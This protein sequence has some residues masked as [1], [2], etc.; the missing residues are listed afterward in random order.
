MRI[1]LQSKYFH[2]GNL[3]ETFLLEPKTKAKRDLKRKREEKKY[4]KPTKAIPTP[5]PKKISTSN[6]FIK[7]DLCL[8]CEYVWMGH[9]VFLF[10]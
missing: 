1:S 10:F 2:P 3:I 8:H 7:K 5:T 6:D 9:A 4:S